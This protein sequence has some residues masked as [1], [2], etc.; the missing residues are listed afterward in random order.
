MKNI[1]DKKEF[2][3]FLSFLALMFLFLKLTDPDIPEVDYLTIEDDD[4]WFRKARMSQPAP[5]QFM[6]SRIE[7]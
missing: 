3:Y 5:P 1:L 4:S 7:K 6:N 2:W